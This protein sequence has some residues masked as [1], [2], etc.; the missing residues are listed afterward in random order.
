MKIATLIL[1]FL[2]FILVLVPNAQA[3]QAREFSVSFRPTQ[4]SSP[5]NDIASKKIFLN[6]Q[7]MAQTPRL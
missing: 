3:K 7:I 1:L 5:Q 4:P 2:S 6:K